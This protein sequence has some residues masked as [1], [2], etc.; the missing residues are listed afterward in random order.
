MVVAGQGTAQLCAVQLLWLFEVALRVF[1]GP[2][3]RNEA[4]HSVNCRG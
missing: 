3:G 1:L 2:E 4:R